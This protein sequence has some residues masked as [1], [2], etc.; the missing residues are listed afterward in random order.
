MLGVSHANACRV[1][2]TT[3]SLKRR[4]APIDLQR[5]TAGRGAMFWRGVTLGS[6]HAPS[7]TEDLGRSSGHTPLS[8]LEAVMRRAG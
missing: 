7:R 1:V 5:R 4:E 8:G 2:F 3:L 6:L